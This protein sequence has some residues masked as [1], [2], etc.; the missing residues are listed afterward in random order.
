[1]GASSWPVLSACVP[2]P[3]AGAL[4]AVLPLIQNVLH[5]EPYNVF[6][7]EPYNVVLSQLHAL[8]TIVACLYEI[9]ISF[10]TYH[11]HLNLSEANVSRHIST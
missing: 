6:H 8:R 2:P 1:M 4:M 9:I 7:P 10:Q 5:P 3:S 11:E